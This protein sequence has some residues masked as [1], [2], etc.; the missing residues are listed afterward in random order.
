VPEYIRSGSV[1]ESYTGQWK[2]DAV[3]KQVKMTIRGNTALTIIAPT[4]T[5]LT[6]KAITVPGMREGENLKL[7]YKQ[8]R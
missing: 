8:N 5:E 2:Y 6:M 1:K 4:E 3:K 7:V